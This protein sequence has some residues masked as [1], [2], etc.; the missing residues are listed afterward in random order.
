MLSCVIPEESPCVEAE[1]GHQREGAHKYIC[2]ITN[3][4]DA[5]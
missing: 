1:D 3:V 5:M 4:V 2:I